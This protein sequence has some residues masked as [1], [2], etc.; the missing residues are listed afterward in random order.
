MK[1]LIGA[2]N[3]D[4]ALV[5]AFSVIVKSRVPSDILRMKLYPATTRPALVTTVGIL[6]YDAAPWSLL[7][8]VLVTGDVCRKPP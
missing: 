4:K 8:L 1:V 3:Q 7:L 5:G 2:F 6:F